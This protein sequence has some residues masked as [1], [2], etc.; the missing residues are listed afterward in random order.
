V[1]F[2]QLLQEQGILV[3]VKVDTGLQP[4]SGTEGETATQGLDGLGER[5][6]GYYLEGA[7]FAKWRAVLK[8]GNGMP[9]ERAVLENAQTLARYASICQEHGLVPII[10]PEV[11]L[12]PGDYS[13]DR[14]AY[15]GQRVLSHVFRALNSHDV[16]LE[17][18][19]LKPSMVLP[20]L[21]ATLA[22]NDK[23][24]VARYTVQTML[25]GVPP[26]VPGIH[27]LS[28]G[29][30][31]EEATHNL[32][33]LQRA[34]PNSPWALSFSYGRALQDPVLK[35]WGGDEENVAIAQELLVELARVNADAQLGVWNEE[36]PS[37]G[38]ARVLLPKF[39]YAEERRTPA[40]LFNW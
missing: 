8:I 26:A 9:S 38:N 25:R 24:E 22:E 21:D 4:L 27:F 31:A 5:C 16:I 7:R 39:S 13:I 19:L 33:A 28:G 14:A 40:N 3:G 18:M 20:G 30:G 6:K 29:M 34:C 15:E 32:Q 2:T 36:H 10:E 17:A 35:A 12:G 11:A 1:R 23:D 37:P